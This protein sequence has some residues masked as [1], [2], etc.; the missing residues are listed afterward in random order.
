MN[1]SVKQSEHFLYQQGEKSRQ[2][3]V[4]FIDI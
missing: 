3:L 1:N 2:F 4:N